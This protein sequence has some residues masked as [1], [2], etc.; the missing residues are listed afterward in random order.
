MIAALMVA[1]FAFASR[2]DLFESAVISSLAMLG[3]DGANGRFYT[4]YNYK[5]L[6]SSPALS[7]SVKCSCCDRRLSLPLPKG[8]NLLMPPDAIQQGGVASVMIRDNT[9]TIGYVKWSED[10]KSLSYKDLELSI[11]SCC[12]FVETQFGCAQTLLAELLLLGKD[13]HLVDVLPSLPLHKGRVNLCDVKIGW[14]FLQDSRNR[15]LLR[16]A[17]LGLYVE[18]FPMCS[19]GTTLLLRSRPTQSRYGG[20]SLSAAAEGV[21]HLSRGASRLVHLT[22]GQLAQT[23]Q[24]SISQTI[25]GVDLV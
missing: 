2:S 5:L 22:S 7:K 11:S 24:Q 8:V 9:R 19:F 25:Q 16:A 3:I 23:S 10:D 15:D 20:Q 17:V 13:E 18:C 14:N 4:P 6:Q 12:E 1:A 21:S